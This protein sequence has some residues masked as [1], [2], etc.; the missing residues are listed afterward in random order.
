M[1]CIPMIKFDILPQYCLPN[2]EREKEYEESLAQGP[3]PVV[4]KHCK[5]YFVH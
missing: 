4:S 5:S 1:V 3:E 2:Q